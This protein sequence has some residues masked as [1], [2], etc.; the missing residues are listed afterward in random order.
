[1]HLMI[2]GVTLMK[3][4]H[5]RVKCIG[6]DTLRKHY[7]HNLMVDLFLFDCSYTIEQ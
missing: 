3:A 5:P 1:M 4:H 7:S 6:F 2:I